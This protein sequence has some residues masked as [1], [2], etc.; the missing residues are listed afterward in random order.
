MFPYLRPAF[1][2]ILFLGILFPLT[3]AQPQHHA[4]SLGP[5]L[6]FDRIGVADGLPNEYVNRIVQDRFG[7]M[8][9]ATQNGLCRY[10]GQEFKTFN[11][12][13]GDS[14]SLASNEIQLVFSDAKGAL[15]FAANGLHRFNFE[16]E[17]FARIVPSRYGALTNK[18]KYLSSIC[19]DNTGVLWLGTFGQGLFRFDPASGQLA[20]VDL[21]AKAPTSFGGTLINNISSSGSDTIWIASSG[22]QL[23]ALN[24][25]TNTQT[26]Y[27]LTQKAD[28]QYVLCDRAGRVW[29]GAT[30]EPLKLVHPRPDGRL[31]FTPYEDIK[32]TNYFTCLRDDR[33]GNLWIGTQLEGVFLLNPITGEIQ[34]YRHSTRD[35]HTLP[36]E[37]ILD[38][39]EDRSGNVWIAT[40]KGVAKWARWKK[41][42]QHFSYDTE[43]TNSINN[44][45]V[46]GIDQDANGDLWIS[47]FNAGFCKF[48]PRTEKFTRFDPTT[49]AIKS[50]WA[51]EILADRNGFVWVATN[52]QH[53]LNRFDVATGR[54]KE[55]LNS[56]QDTTSLGSNL[57][58]TLY[59]DHLGRIWVGPAFRG[60]NLYE[61]R[62]ENFRRFKHDP[63]NPTTL[64]H[65]NVLSI[66]QDAAR[67]LWIGT[68]NGLN[69]FDDARSSFIGYFP[70]G[71]AED[72]SKVFEVYA[73]HEDARRRFWLGTNDGLYLFDR[74]SGKFERFAE[75]RELPERKA[76]GIL[77]DGE[78]NLWLQGA[79][80]VAKFYPDNRALRV[81]DRE[82]GWIQSV[83]NAQE[84]MHAYE[85][86][87]SDEMAFGGSN[88]ITIFDPDSVRDN[89][90]MPPVH[91]TGFKLFYES[92]DVNKNPGGRRPKEDSLLTHS[93]LLADRLTLNHSEHT[94]SFTVAAL[95]YTQPRANQ[96]AYMLEGFDDDW[97][98]CGNSHTAT[99][100]NVPSGEYIFR[101]KGSNSNGLWNETGAQ[102]GITILPP[103]WK[104]TTAYIG[105]AALFGLIILTQRRFELNRVKMR[106]QLAMKEFEARK[107]L[108]V[109]HLKSR[110]FANISHEFRTPLTLI[111][112][113]LEDVI[114]K[115]KDK[116]AGEN[117]RIMARSANRL[118]RLINQLLDLSRLESGRMTLHARRGDFIG[119]LR[120][121]VMS[122]ASLAEQKKIALKFASELE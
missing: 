59:Q 116:D 68:G 40:N 44:A 26:R 54:F 35:L 46:T 42:F 6:A 77:E 22:H 107:L 119:F 10:D 51:I 64:S 61:P 11:S 94:F 71:I 102:I 90:E 17:N 52:F 96:Y 93:L 78:G 91:L 101:V 28:L 69:R 33:N 92:V 87:A 81:Y 37:E 31:S 21:G 112:G 89:P 63:S 16:H 103:W 12:V 106:N 38:I 111:L 30:G 18:L 70:P 74:E 108:E 5:R 105:Y 86:L 99:F 13:P 120:G 114:A 98:D 79:N 53:G 67:T 19:E 45:E 48:N 23:T 8:W 27:A 56:R 83:V 100:T 65:G 4:T 29:L 57:V 115:V 62:S 24:T 20:E 60:L 2:Q 55:F 32:A 113:P 121:I 34:Q 3:S 95:D 109:D 75:L 80:A 1:L 122:F 76:F 82:D 50:P 9:F 85:R 73:M 14:A 39:Y 66:F 36:G 58:A 110:F 72:Q 118:L 88:G 41:P 97:V 25:R 84:W 117:L 49:C 104:S 15:W 47:T 7:F 43:S